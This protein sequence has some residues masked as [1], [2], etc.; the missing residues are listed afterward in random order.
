VP[1][2]GPVT[3][4]GISGLI[5]DNVETGKLAAILSDKILKGVPAG[6]I[7]VVSPEANLWVNYKAMQMLGLKTPERMLSRATQIIR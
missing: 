2:V 1:V 7:P 4:G 6:T 3:F 5:I